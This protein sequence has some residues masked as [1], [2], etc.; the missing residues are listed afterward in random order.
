MVL[1]ASQ[2]SYRNL[3]LVSMAASDSEKDKKP[4]PHQI[5]IDIKVF[6]CSVYIMPRALLI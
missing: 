6:M 4:Q 3:K 2:T 5:L 1:A